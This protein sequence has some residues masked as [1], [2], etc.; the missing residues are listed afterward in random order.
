VTNVNSVHGNGDDGELARR[1]KERDPQA[2]AELY[3]RYGRMAFLL[4]YRI[5]GDTGAA[6]DTVQETFL[7]VWNSVDS[8]DPSRGALGRWILSVA[9]NR[10]IDYVRSWEGRQV[11][12]ASAIQEWAQPATPPDF[13]KDVLNLDLRLAMRDAI[14]R[15]TPRQRE[16]LDLA[17]VEE[18]TQTEM[19]ERLSRP[20]GTVKT[21]VRGALQA[22]RAEMAPYR[23]EA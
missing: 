23:Q 3:D 12:G 17:Y 15:L 11:R 13:E 7:K 20:L 10:A 2:V 4:V 21:W 5:I 14:R 16:I 19:A 18:L 8:Y 6:E 22:L 1:L 9:R